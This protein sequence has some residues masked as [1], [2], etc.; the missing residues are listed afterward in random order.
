[1][2]LADKFEL[3]RDSY[4]EDDALDPILDKLLDAALSQQRSRLKRYEH[5]LQTFEARYGMSSSLFYERFEGGE[6]GDAMDFFE[7]ASL[8]ELHQRALDKVKR[9]ESVS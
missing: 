5:D 7:W 8:I 6:L 1:M 2:V 9:L 3:L 4:A